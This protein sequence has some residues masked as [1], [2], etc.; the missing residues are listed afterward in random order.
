MGF[1]TG[2]HFVARSGLELV[3]FLP[4][5]LSDGITGL[6]YNTWLSLPFLLGLWMPWE[7]NSYQK[8]HLGLSHLFLRCWYIESLPW[9]VCESGFR[10]SQRSPAIR[11]GLSLRMCVWLDCKWLCDLGQN[12]APAS[13]SLL[14][15][16]TG[17]RK[18]GIGLMVFCSC[19]ERS[20]SP[21]SWSSDLLS[22][23]RPSHT[24]LL[25]EL[26]VPVPTPVS[27]RPCWR[28]MDKQPWHSEVCALGT[29]RGKGERQLPCGQSTKHW[30]GHQG[31]PICQ[32]QLCTHDA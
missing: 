20:R 1:E 26:P 13:T 32:V 9:M 28:Q 23:P 10:E 3:I 29:P 4:L 22:H 15:F 14:S 24:H 5:F 27:Q 12:L 19:M 2:S 7:K 30:G 17:N 25:C 8:G 11:E 31:R 16:E 21:S 6:P 18:E